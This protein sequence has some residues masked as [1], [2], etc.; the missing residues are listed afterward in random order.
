MTRQPVPLAIASSSCSTTR[1]RGRDAWLLPLLLLAGLI[2][3]SWPTLVALFKDWQGDDDY[4]VCQ[5]VPLAALYLLWS[6]RRQLARVQ[7]QPCWWG[8]GL[9]LLAQVAR[10]YG[11]VFMFESAERYSIILT[12]AGLTLLVGGRQLFRQVFWILL[13]LFLMVPLPGRVHNMVSGPLQGLAT[14]L[15]VATLEMVGVSVVREGHTMILNDSTP[16]AVAEACSGLRMLT[17]FVIVSCFLAYAVS[18][19]RWQRAV[20]VLSSIPVAIV[21]NQVRLVVTAVFFLTV[22]SKFGER[23][24]HDFAGFTMMPL[25]VLML[26]GE[27]WIMSKLVI[28]DDNRNNKAPV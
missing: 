10:F 16:L 19:P 18:R 17:A 12:V 2:L 11:L 26:A 9:I 25:A 8:A 3:S 21:C 23:F 15:A 7:I 13:F 4:S 22:S 24:F 27:L 1:P 5:L 20:M 14:T 6:D 28:N